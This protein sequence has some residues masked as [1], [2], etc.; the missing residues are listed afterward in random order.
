MEINREERGNIKRSFRKRL[1]LG[2]M[3][4]KEGVITQRQLDE[5]LKEQNKT[6]EKLGQIL[7]RLE[8]VSEEVILKFLSTQLSI[9]YITSLANI[10]DIPKEV[11]EIIPEF[12]IRRRKLFPVSMDKN[13]L[14]VAMADPLDIFA[15]D[16]VKVLIGDMKISPVI[17][18]EREITGLIEKY[19]GKSEV[20]EEI[21]RDMETEEVEV[22]EEKEEE[23]D[24]S[25]LT[26]DSKSAP[27]IRLVNHLLLEAIKQGASDIHIEPYQK[28]MR[29]RYRVDG[30]LH[31]AG[32]QPKSIQGAIISRIKIISR[33]DIAERRLPQDGR[34]QV[35]VGG[36]DVDLR[37]SVTPTNFGEKVVIRILDPA[38]LCLDLKLLGFEPDALRIYEQLIRSP[39]GLVLI[40]GPTGSG[41]TTTL[42]STLT[43]IN[44]PDKNI[45]TVE[46]PVEYVLDG[47]NQQHVNPE[48]GL[49]FAAGL[50]SFLRQDPDIVLVGEIRDKETAEVAINAALTGHLVF[51]TLHTNDACGAVTRLINMGVE[52]FLIA[53]TVIMAVAQRLVRILCPRCKQPYEAVPEVLAQIGIDIGEKTTIYR[54]EGCK[55][56][57]KIGYK[58]RG[59]IYE[60]VIMDD[61]IKDMVI[62]GEP[63]SAIKKKAIEK[64]MITLHEAAARKVLEGKTTIGEILRV[65]M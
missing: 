63:V 27:V 19:Y 51:S 40:T 41:K 2:D 24:L 8:F 12:F 7:I 48:I 55:Y 29:T 38:S 16:D 30:V 64:G 33:L 13:V 26:T 11:M 3:L 39:W 23:V 54:E 10:E 59:G 15:L 14:T 56:C 37:V 52:P 6:N 9:S 36:R 22:K 45:M 46:D 65:T 62:K 50:R 17:A 42:Y 49:S 53:S 31:D 4:V 20:L 44:A 43:T 18:S 34:A 28:H 32:H 47:I 5:A 58:G 60:I 21:M 25:K 57:H 61:E 35:K 1:R